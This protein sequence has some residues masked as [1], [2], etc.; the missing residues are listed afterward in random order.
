MS[1]LFF[2]ALLCATCFHLALAHSRMALH[3]NSALACAQNNATKLRLSIVVTTTNTAPQDQIERLTLQIENIQY[4]TELYHLEH[5][6]EY[7]VVEY[8]YD[9]ASPSLYDVL[10]KSFKDSSPLVRII[11]VSAE[12]HEL[13]T[14]K[15][16]LDFKTNFLEFYAKNIGIRRA[17]GQFVLPTNSD[18]SFS[19][20]FWHFLSKATLRTDA[21]Y[22]LPRCNVNG[23]L[24]ALRTMSVPDRYNKLKDNTVDCWWCDPIVGTW[25]SYMSAPVSSTYA[26]LHA[27]QW[28]ACIYAPGDFLLMSK[29]NFVRF[30]GY[31]DVALPHQLDD[32]P[33]WQAVGAGLYLIV[34]PKPAL[35]LHI[36]H[37]KTY[38]ANDGRWHHAH[39]MVNTYRFDEAGQRMMRD[40]K[41]EVF[42]DEDWGLAGSLLEEDIY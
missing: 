38:I 32:V 33:V 36:N 17:C 5:D 34:V 6:V 9:A 24:N 18:I 4:Y 7:I 8:N 22:R 21:Y 23:D 3:F 20:G 1:L 37:L 26:D 28:R 42:N 39:E 2:K 30:R 25:A 35:G 13:I 10:Q 16:G 15:M 27:E 29:A 12:Q 40:H 11:R 31:P 41:L 19:D 14:H